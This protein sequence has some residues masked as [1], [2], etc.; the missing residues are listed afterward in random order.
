MSFKAYA[1]NGTQVADNTFHF[2]ATST[3]ISFSKKK[4]WKKLLC[5]SPWQQNITL[6]HISYRIN[7]IAE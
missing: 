4:P 3:I 1:L 6:F 5:L 2:A 7:T